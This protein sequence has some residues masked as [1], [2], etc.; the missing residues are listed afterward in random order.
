MIQKEI[1]LKRIFGR[2]KTIGLSL[3]A[4][5][6]PKLHKDKTKTLIKTKK[7]Q[8]SWNNQQKQ[9]LRPHVCRA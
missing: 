1:S 7:E 2:L 4:E 6:S 9:S 3:Q 8:S 5:F